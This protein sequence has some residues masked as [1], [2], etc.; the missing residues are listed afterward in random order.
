VLNGALQVVSASRSFYRNFAVTPDETVGRSIYDLG[1]RQWDIPALREL[2]ETLLP[3]DRG[4]EGYVVEHDFPV[5]GRRRM[6]L[7]ASRIVGQKGD[8]QL[9]LLAMEESPC[10]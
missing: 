10:P 4:F 1:N 2:L 3:R 7:N 5:I 9:I 6:L 8:T